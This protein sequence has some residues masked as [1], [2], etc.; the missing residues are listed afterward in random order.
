MLLMLPLTALAQGKK[1]PADTCARFPFETYVQSVDAEIYQRYRLDSMLH[2]NAHLKAKI[3]VLQDMYQ[4]AD[5][6]YLT[7][8]SLLEV[9]QEDHEEDLDVMARSYKEHSQECFGRI[10]DLM[11][12]RDEALTAKKRWRKAAAGA[13]GGLVLYIVLRQQF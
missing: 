2:V 7:C 3:K 4:T 6:R 11:A 13:L 12:E 9:L 5:G 1:I 8:D 10:E